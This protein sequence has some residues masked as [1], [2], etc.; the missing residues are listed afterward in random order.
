VYLVDTLPRPHTFLQL[1]HV[2]I[3]NDDIVVYNW[4]DYALYLSPCFY[5]LLEGC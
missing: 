3:F 4:E 1:T 2:E 5:L